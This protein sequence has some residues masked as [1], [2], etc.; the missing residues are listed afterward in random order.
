VGVRF[1][2]QMDA[3]PVP[4]RVHEPSDAQTRRREVVNVLADA[5]LQ[6]LLRRHQPA[7]P[8]AAAGKTP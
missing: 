5:L 7:S 1:A 2:M 8:V 4:S 3:E 6:L